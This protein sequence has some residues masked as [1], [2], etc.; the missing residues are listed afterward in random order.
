MLRAVLA[1]EFLRK[2]E[3]KMQMTVKATWEYY[4]P[5][6]KTV[7]TNGQSCNIYSIYPL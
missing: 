2:R 6:R 1:N 7:K 5:S 4:C 3:K